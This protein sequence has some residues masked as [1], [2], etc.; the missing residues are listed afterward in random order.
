MVRGIPGYTEGR[1]VDPLRRTWNPSPRELAMWVRRAV[2]AGRFYPDDPAELREQIRSELGRSAVRPVEGVK[3]LIVPNAGYAYSAPVAAS[4]YAALGSPAS[5]IDR[6]LLLGTCHSPGVDGLA[7]TSAG[8]FETP[9]GSVPVDVDAVSEALL[10][11]QVK[12]HDE[13]QGRDHALEV[14]LPF[15]QVIFD[16]FRILPFLVGRADAASVAELLF[17]AVAM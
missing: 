14:Q 4:G 15:L 2:V 9:L 6:V 8:A 12:T 10:L 1:P 17:G 16:H 7:A 13:I 11:P 5:E 3:A